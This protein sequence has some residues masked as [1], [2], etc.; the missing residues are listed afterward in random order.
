MEQRKS[1]KSTRKKVVRIN[2]NVNSCQINEFLFKISDMI[3]NK[4]WQ[5]PTLSLIRIGKIGN[6]GKEQLSQNMDI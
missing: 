3:Q 5:K 2:T 6:Q 4:D 1:S